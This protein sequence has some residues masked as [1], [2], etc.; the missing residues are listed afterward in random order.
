MTQTIQY[1]V[2]FA[3]V[4]GGN[5][6]TRVPDFVKNGLAVPVH[7]ETVEEAKAE[8]LEIV[9]GYIND[10]EETGGEYPTPSTLLE[11]IDG[12][13]ATMDDA[14]HVITYVQAEYLIL[15]EQGA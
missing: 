15:E 4:E 2:I 13:K 14:G 10:I 1:P 5:I 12:F 9:K 8:A 6:I 3:R 11:A 7:E